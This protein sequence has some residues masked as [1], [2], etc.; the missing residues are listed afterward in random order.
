MNSR[1]LKKH[2][3]YIVPEMRL[4]LLKEPCVKPQPIYSPDCLGKFVEPM[5]HYRDYVPRQF[6]CNHCGAQP[7]G[8]LADTEQ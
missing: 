1:T 5:K 6:A 4:A 8:R 2:L 3:K 7:P